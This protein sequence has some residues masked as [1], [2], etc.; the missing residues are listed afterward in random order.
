MSTLNTQTLRPGL[1][2]ALKTS[3]TGNVS[4]NKVDLE[5][6]RILESGEHVA[7]WEQTRTIADAAEHERATKARG[8][9]R[10][11]IESVCTKSAFGL[12]CPETDADVL[13]KAIKDAR[14]V[15]EVFNGTATLSRVAIYVI[16][17]RVAS[18]DVEAVKA[19]NSEVREL[20]SEMQAGVET[21]NVQ[22][23]RAAA[24][25]AKEIGGMLTPDAQA[26]I[27]VAIEAARK[28]AREIVSAGET[29]AGEIDRRVIRTLTEARTAFLDLDEVGDVAQTFIPG[30]AVDLT[31][32]AEKGA[33][34]P[35]AARGLDLI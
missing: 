35:I 17:G 19:I 26:R 25:K 3:V 12:L 11:M 16:S 15:V 13:T 33:V 18:D 34:A 23:I 27:T 32:E 29:A 4:Y 24:T 31:P 7:K 2:V 30:R 28:T 10:R 8:V 6:G 9:A 14:D 5:T 22:Q 20:L 21:L 1:L